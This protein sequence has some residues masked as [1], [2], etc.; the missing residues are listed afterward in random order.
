MKALAKLLPEKTVPNKL[1]SLAE[2][3]SG[4]NA[5]NVSLHLLV[6]CKDRNQLKR[7]LFNLQVEFRGSTERPGHAGFLNVK[8]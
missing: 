8:L 6:A 3:V 5:E 7:D 2:N 4:Q 1:V